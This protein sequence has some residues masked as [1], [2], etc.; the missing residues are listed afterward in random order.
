MGLFDFND[1][2]VVGP[3]LN[4]MAQVTAAGVSAHENKKAMERQFKMN[5]YMAEWQNEVN[6]EN[7]RMQNAYNSP[8]AQMERYRQAGLNPN[9]VTG[10]SNSSGNAGSIPAFDAPRYEAFHS[11]D[12][13]SDKLPD[14]L[15]SLMQ[16]AQVKKIE[17]ET[18]NLKTYQRNMNTENDYNQLRMIG[19]RA[20]NSKSDYEA[21]IWSEYWDKKLLQMSIETKL[22]DANRLYTDSQRNY[23]DSQ[24]N[25][26]EGPKTEN[27]ITNTARTIADIGL[28]QYRKE[29]MQSQVASYLASAGLSNAQANRIT[30]LLPLEAEYM[31]TQIGSNLAKTEYQRFENQV[32]DAFLQSGVDLREGRLDKQFVKSLAWQ[33]WQG[34]KKFVQ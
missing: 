9:L 31:G 8:S 6:K 33:L 4:A 2:N 11:W 3:A 26:L 30:S 29:V 7:W 32:F 18:A 21:S 16:V 20:L 17:Q 25:Y 24:R 27:T 23:V 22:K 13:V 34:V 14:I 5:K 10:S 15:N 19:Q 28:M 12:K 1:V